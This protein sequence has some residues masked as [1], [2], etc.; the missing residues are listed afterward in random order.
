MTTSARAD[1]KR[2]EYK[3]YYAKLPIAHIMLVYR[4]LQRY[5]KIKRGIY[6]R[7]EGFI[8]V[9][10]RSTGV[11]RGI[12]GYTSVYRGYVKVYNGIQ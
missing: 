4:G 10:Q 8:G 11:Y 2:T 7:I 5:T 6:R 1:T 3:Y 12:R 9:T